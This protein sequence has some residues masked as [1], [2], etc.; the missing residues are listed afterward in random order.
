MSAAIVNYGPSRI[1]I[2]RMVG[3]PTG[4]VTFLFSDIEGST[5]LSRRHGP[6]FGDLR[7]E[8]RRLL[9]EV[10]EA[11]RGHEIDAEGD[12]FFVAFERAT[13]AVA[14]AVAAQRALAAVSP[15]RVRMGLHTTEPHVYAEGYVGVGVS[16]AARI[17]G[18]AHGG[19]IVLSHA[20]AGV[21]E[22]SETAEVALRDLGEHY[23]KDIPR[24]QRLFQID[25]DGLSSEFPPLGT[26]LAG[27]IATLLFID[28]FDWQRV[29]QELGDDG[30]AAAVAA[31]H[32]IIGQTANVHGG[33]QVERAGDHAMCVFG[34][35]KDALVAAA[36]IRAALDASDWVSGTAKPAVKAAVH[37]GRL[38]GL[39]GGQLGSPAIRVIRLCD[40]AEPGQTLVS[41]STQ[42]L[43]EGELLGDLALRDLGEQRLPGVT[44]S[45]V[46][47]LSGSFAGS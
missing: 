33:S 40:S 10:F 19:Q 1:T 27:T 15:V 13:D 8:H 45:H 43:L 23:L 26:R 21:I 37:T 22:D 14:A 29:M 41:H 17:C 39:Y 32:R 7:A 3:L 16:R 46:Y 20:T 5:E 11:H 36:A 28:V 47:E 38:A 44:P 24:P 6:A 31:Y 18:A 4:T 42:A 9:R 35:A 30:A 2:A 12:A 25:A 34:S